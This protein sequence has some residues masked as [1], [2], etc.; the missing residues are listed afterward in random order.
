MARYRN[1]VILTGAGISAESGLGT[2]RDE[3]GLWA[4]HRI[5]DVATPEGFARNPEL[6]QAFYNSRRRDL[7]TAKPNPAHLALARLERDL[8]PGRVTLVTQN[9]DNL[10]EQA[11]SETV[12]HMH[13]ELQ[14]A[15]C[16]ACGRIHPW[17]DDLSGTT[18][19]PACAATALRPHVVWFGE[20]PLHMDAIERHL[21]EAD[22]FV[23][24]GTSGAV[25]PAAG[26][27][28][29]ARAYGRA[30]TVELNRDPSDGAGFFADGRYG[31]ASQVVPAFVE[32]ILTG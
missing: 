3:D 18:P 24:I 19:C 4:K 6:V 32:E 14:K 12:L 25:Y 28:Q 10:H 9:V 1:V 2:F 31:L 23:S 20:I 13:G 15:R 22:L 7:A 5:E 27:V 8:G 11:G 16:T 21:A 17:L 29:M 30:A 26:F